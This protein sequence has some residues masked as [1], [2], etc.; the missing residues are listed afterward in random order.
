MFLLT[1]TWAIIVSSKLQ[2]RVA[3]L[4]WRQ[5][6]LKIIIARAYYVTLSSIF[7]ASQYHTGSPISTSCEKRWYIMNTDRDNRATA[8]SCKIV[9]Y[10]VLD[11]RDSLVCINACI[12]TTTIS[13]LP[14]LLLSTASPLAHSQAWI[15]PQMTILL[16]I[17]A[18]ITDILRYYQYSFQQHH[19]AFLFVYSVGQGRR[20]HAYIEHSCVEILAQRSRAVVLFAQVRLSVTV[21][22]GRYRGSINA[23]YTHPPISPSLILSLLPPLPSLSPSLSLLLR[24]SFQQFLAV[25][26]GRPYRGATKGLRG[27][28]WKFQRRSNPQLGGRRERQGSLGTGGG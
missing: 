14:L 2:S 12:T 22:E 7:D 3:V 26:T 4:S 11:Q 6:Q 10:R 16:Y 20:D 27:H 17:Y 21:D 1:S 23:T 15:H 19:R 8:T 28:G 25:F 13:L 9:D 5:Y 18:S 24:S